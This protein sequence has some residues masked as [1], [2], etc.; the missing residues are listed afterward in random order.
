METFIKKVFSMYRNG[1]KKRIFDPPPHLNRL[2]MQSSRANVYLQ[3]DFLVLPSTELCYL[4]NELRGSKSYEADA[5]S[6]SI[7]LENFSPKKQDP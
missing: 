2:C 5:K 3:F 6:L 7:R 4:L 1:D